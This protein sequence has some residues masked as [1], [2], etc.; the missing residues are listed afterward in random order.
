MELHRGYKNL[1]ND[2][3]GYLTLVR[4]P[5]VNFDPRGAKNVMT[6]YSV[7]PNDFKLSTGV[8]Y[9]PRT[10]VGVKIDPRNPFT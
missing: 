8:K 3:R 4:V 5:G 10:H 6:F 7:E 1:T 9:D 2:F